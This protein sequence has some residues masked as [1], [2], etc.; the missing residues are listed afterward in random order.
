MWPMRF[1]IW[2]VIWHPMSQGK[3]SLWTAHAGY[4]RQICLVFL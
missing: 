1:C 4:S 2:P 3:Y